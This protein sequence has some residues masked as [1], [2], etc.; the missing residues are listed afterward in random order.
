MSNNEPKTR[1]RIMPASAQSVLDESRAIQELIREL[2][3]QVSRLSE[4]NMALS[5]KLDEHEKLLEQLVSDDA[6]EKLY[7]HV[8]KRFDDQRNW[9]YDEMERHAKDSKTRDAHAKIYLEQIH[10]RD[11]ET[12]REAQMRMFRDIP[13]ATGKRRLSQMATAKLMSELDRIC[14]ALGLEYWFAYGTLVA[15]LYRNGSIPWD[16]DIDICMRRGDI[17]CLKDYLDGDSDDAEKYQVTVVYDQFVKCRQVRFSS[18]DENIPVFIDLSI[19]DL[20]PTASEGADK[21]LTEMRLELMD[22]LEAACHDEDSPVSYWASHPFLRATDSLGCS[23]VIDVDWDALDT[24]AE[25]GAAAAIEE[26]FSK[27]QDAAIEEGL[28]GEGGGLAYAMDNI[29]DAP[30]RRVTWPADMFVPTSDCLYDGYK[31]QVPAKCD[32]VVQECYPGSPYLPDDII[33]HEHFADGAMDSPEVVAALEAFV[34]G[35]KEK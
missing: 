22:E 1:R 32:A 27:Y 5:A 24:G 35:D 2:S 13:A 15:A 23:Q 17:E 9:T 12:P 8:D 34:S 26:I 7:E 14:S 21:R 20:C 25:A 4:A 33:G 28:L 3:G 16:D 31:F 18:T 29:Y 30:W 11:G 6:V 19:W 10:R